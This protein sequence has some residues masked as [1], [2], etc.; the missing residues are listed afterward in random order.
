LALKSANRRCPARVERRA[1]DDV[2]AVGD[3]IGIDPAGGSTP[4]R[5]ARLGF[6]DRLVEKVA[7]PCR[8]R[9]IGLGVGEVVDLVDV[10][11]ERRPSLCAPFIWSKT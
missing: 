3:D 9:H 1:A 7:M 10:D 11:Q 6:G 2:A 5:L 4:L 8:R